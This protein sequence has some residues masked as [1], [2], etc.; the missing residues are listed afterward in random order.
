MRKDS[1]KNSLSYLESGLLEVSS[2]KSRLSELV[3]SKVKEVELLVKIRTEEREH[4]QR[5]REFI[6]VS[7]FDAAIKE[8]EKVENLHQ[9][10]TQLWIQIEKLQS[11]ES[12]KRASLEASE[13]RRA[14]EEEQK[15]AALN[16][17]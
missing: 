15:R 12:D 1:F 7:E 14:E 2:E 3:H 6:N 11:E 16:Q 13:R 5:S 4:L 17:T 10:K 9:E 8:L